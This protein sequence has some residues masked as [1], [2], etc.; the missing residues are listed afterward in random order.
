MGIKY[1]DLDEILFQITEAEGSNQSEFQKYFSQEY[2][3]ELYTKV[4]KM[5]ASSEF[6][7]NLPP[8]LNRNYA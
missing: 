1:A 8:V 5:V 6:K 2:P 4:G 3:P 7:R